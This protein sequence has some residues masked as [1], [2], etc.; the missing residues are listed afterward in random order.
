[1]GPYSK[2]SRSVMILTQSLP[3]T[4]NNPLRTT[5]ED[6]DFISWYTLWPP[7]RQ[8]ADSFLEITHMHTDTHAHTLCHTHRHTLSHAETYK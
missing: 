7:S 6:F 1:M 5:L 2:L 3:I 8:W 4:G